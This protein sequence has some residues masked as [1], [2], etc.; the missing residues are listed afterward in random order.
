MIDGNEAYSWIIT[1][2]FQLLNHQISPAS[3]ALSCSDCHGETARMNLKAEL[4]YQLKASESKVCT[5]CHGKEER[6]GFKDLH[7]EHVEEEE[8]DCSHCHTFSRPER[9]LR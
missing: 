7:E 5:Q 4:G 2:T 8:Y 3:E 1:D 6:K 9:N